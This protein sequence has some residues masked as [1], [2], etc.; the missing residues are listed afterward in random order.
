MNEETRY[1]IIG[2]LWFFTA[3]VLIALFISAAVIGDLTGAH[4]ALTLLLLGL[5]IT[6]TAFFLRF[7]GVEADRAKAKRERIDTLLSDL[8][9]D[10]LLE[11]KRRLSDNPNPH[12]DVLDYIDDDGELVL[13]ESEDRG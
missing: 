13:R 5:A 9:D 10:D 3:L 8:S 12:R 11:L 2:G 7:E 1:S 4:V 6:G